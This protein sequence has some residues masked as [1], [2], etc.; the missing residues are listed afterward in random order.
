MPTLFITIDTEEDL[1]GEYRAQNNPV[2]NVSHIPDIQELFERVGAIPT[3]LVNWAVVSDQTACATLRRIADGGHCE[4]GTHCHP[5]NTPPFEEELGTRNSMLCNLP[6]SLV[7]KK[8][9]NLHSLIANKFG[10]QPTS[11]RAGRWGFSTQVA[12]CLERLRYTVD[13]SVSPTMNWTRDSGPDYTN[14]LNLP[15]RFD[16]TDVLKENPDGSLLEVPPTIGFWQRN[17]PRQVALQS[18]HSR[19]ASRRLHI[20]GILDRMHLLNHR[21]LSPEQSSASDMIRLAKAVTREGAT[22]LNMCFH[23]NSLLPGATP[24]ARN[25]QERDR[26]VERIRVFLEFAADRGFTFAPL[27]RAVLEGRRT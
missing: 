2:E 4:I 17:H 5:W 6:P 10:S 8:L 27:S 7:Y 14:A 9:Q 15:Y 18:R 19:G 21:W 13:T 24:F 16:P 12:S 11:F 22:V 1:W 26:L 20:L 3:Y 23:S 25:T